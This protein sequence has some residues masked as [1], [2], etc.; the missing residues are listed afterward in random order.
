M[1][2][3]YKDYGIPGLPL[4]D[5]LI[6]IDMC[7][8]LGLRIN[9]NITDHL[10]CRS[11]ELGNVHNFSKILDGRGLHIIS[12]NTDILESKNLSKILNCEVSYTKI[13]RNP[14]TVIHHKEELIKSTS[15]ITKKIVLFGVGAAGKYIGPHLKN[16]YDKIC[17][18]FG[19]TLD[20]WAN[21]ISRGWF[22]TTQKHLLI[23]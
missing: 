19:S 22:N 1:G 12:P 16:N 18:D 21:I 7:E 11:E 6:T 9:D 3:N 14:N 15:K 23:K 17:L 13:G 2:D 8:S 20:A 4:N 10:L 5:W